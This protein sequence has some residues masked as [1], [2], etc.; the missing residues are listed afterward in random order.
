MWGSLRSP[1]NVKKT[2]DEA[3][4][5]GVW[6]N[7]LSMPQDAFLSNLEQRLLD[8]YQQQWQSELSHS[9]K[10]RTYRTF[11]SKLEREPYLNLP[12]HLRVQ[13]SRLRSSA[14]SLRVE[15]GRYTLPPTPLEERLCPSCNVIED[16]QHF[17]IDCSIYNGNERR[18]MMDS[19]T[20]LNR[21]F[22]HLIL[23]K[24]KVHIHS[25]DQEHTT[26]LELRSIRL[27]QLHEKTT[28]P[29][30]IM[31]LCLLCLCIL[32]FGPLGPRHV[33]KISSSSSSLIMS[34][35]DD[36]PAPPPAVPGPS[37]APGQLTQL[38]EAITSSQTRMEQRFA[39][40]RDEVRQGQEE[41]ATKAL[42]R[43]KFEKPYTYRRKGNEEQAVFNSRLDETVAEAE[44]ELAAASP[45]AP[46]PTTAISKAR[47]CFKKVGNCSQ[48]GKN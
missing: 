26:P 21:S 39:E 20:A 1:I 47:E 8:Q 23:L 16:E 15:T 34:T 3:G 5:S 35:N 36:L 44:T 12:R 4:F 6:I 27:Y 19:C 32:T 48:S 22:P 28:Q 42:K 46:T 18:S 13:L 43:A 29:P 2:V 9:L 10:L 40:I 17:L 30:V 7:P 33:I 31:T 24:R 38:L 14:H 37:I 45:G 41:A 11:K 25:F